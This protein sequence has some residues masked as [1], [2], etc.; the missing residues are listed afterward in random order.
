MMPDERLTI[1]LLKG[2]NFAQIFRN[3]KSPFIRFLT[4]D[5]YQRTIFVIHFFFVVGFLRKYE[6]KKINQYCGRKFNNPEIL[7]NIKYCKVGSSIFSE[8]DWIVL[9][10]RFF[11]F[12]ITKCALNF[13]VYGLETRVSCSEGN[14][15][16]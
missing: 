15:I 11:F 14:W 1:K 8:M 7:Y 12:D 13:L 4:S 9:R 2:T 3:I 6:N 10:W 5:H 16:T